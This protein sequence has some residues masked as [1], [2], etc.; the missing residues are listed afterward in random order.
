MRCK[1]HYNKNIILE[2][3]QSNFGAEIESFV[4]C[5]VMDMDPGQLA[6]A[7]E[8]TVDY[9]VLDTIDE[10]DVVNFHVEKDI[11]DEEMMDGIF[12]VLAMLEGYAYW[13]GE[14]VFVGSEEIELDFHFSFLKFN[15]KY[16]N[17]KTY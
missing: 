10:M 5:Y 15:G 1:M 16:S 12:Y 14:H 6:G 2:I 13:G 7:F 8:Q 3:L 11:T 17:F 9:A 4:D